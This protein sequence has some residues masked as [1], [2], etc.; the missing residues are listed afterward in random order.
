MC[1]RGALNQAAARVVEQEG[2]AHLIAS[3]VSGKRGILAT[4]AVEGA[5]WKGNRG[6]S[7]ENVK[8]E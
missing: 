2:Q 1:R 7:D 8:R 3:A 6:L 4:A 5:L